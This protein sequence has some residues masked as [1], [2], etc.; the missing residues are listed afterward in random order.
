MSRKLGTTRLVVAMTL[1]GAYCL[2]FLA[3]PPQSWRAY[4]PA[5]TATGPLWVLRQIDAGYAALGVELVGRQLRDGTYLL[6][7]SGAVP[8]LALALVRRGRP[9]DLGCRRPNRFAW[10]LIAVGYVGSLPLLVWMVGGSSFASHYLPQ[11]QRVGF[12]PFALYYLVNMASE[13]FF[14]HGVLLAA[15]RSDWRWP[16]PPREV[17]WSDTGEWHAHAREPRCSSSGNVPRRAWAW[18]PASRWMLRRGLQWLGLAQPVARPEYASSA[19]GDRSPTARSTTAAPRNMVASRDAVVPGSTVG[20]R[21]TG[22]LGLPGGCVPAIVASAVL[23]SLVHVGKDAREL[24]LSL[25]GGVALGYLAYRTNT[26][27][28]PFVLHL[29]T[30]GTAC[31]MMLAFA[32]VP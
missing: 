6:L 4:L 5:A 14:F 7:M 13:H 3:R 17:A 15:F 32:P 25:P 29:A 27:L 2:V 31:L 21:I 26:W 16:A 19:E 20:S 22:W 18:H 9:Y 28:T 23:F 8:W 1:A 12:W 24:L 11:L 30:A 10:R